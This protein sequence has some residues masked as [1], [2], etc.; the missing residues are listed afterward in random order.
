MI[1]PV[2]YRVVVK[3]E[4]VEEITQGGI[5]LAR[6]AKLA[7]EQA[8]D[9]G[10]VIQIGPS[11]FHDEKVAG[12]QLKIGDHVVYAKYAGKRVKDKDGV[13]YLVINDEDIVA[14]LKD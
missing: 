14:I 8:I 6:E 2:G 1:E 7:E 5:I 9:R 4:N 10:L 11:A 3:P 12:T 13:D